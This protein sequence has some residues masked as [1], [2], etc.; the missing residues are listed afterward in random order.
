MKKP[1]KAKKQIGYMPE[2]VP[3]YT[4]LTVKEFVTYMAELKQV[5]RKQRKESRK[6]IG[7]SQK[8]CCLVT[9]I[10]QTKE[11]IEHDNNQL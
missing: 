10:L 4:D 5:N 6:K 3:L 9:R 11:D 2:G 8:R 1:K 7:S